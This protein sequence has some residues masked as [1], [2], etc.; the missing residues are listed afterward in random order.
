MRLCLGLPL[1][2]RV[3]PRCSQVVSFHLGLHRL[4]S[5]SLCCSF[6]VALLVSVSVGFTVFDS[7]SLLLTF[8]S[9][10]PGA[11]VT[12]TNQHFSLGGLAFVI[13]KLSGTASAFPGWG[14]PV[15][16]GTSTQDTC[17]HSRN[18]PGLWFGSR[19]CSWSERHCGPPSARARRPLGDTGLS[20][21]APSVPRPPTTGQSS[22]GGCPFVG[23]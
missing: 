16:G 19:T 9:A 14:S 11:R 13:C 2:V 5:A 21:P 7:L 12:E 23:G 15:A 17:T 20:Q 6:S 1:S 18:T 22:R 8:L 10:F 3:F 4:V